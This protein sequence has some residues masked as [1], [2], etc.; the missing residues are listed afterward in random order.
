MTDVN[1]Q[2]FQCVCDG[3]VGSVKAALK[4]GAQVNAKDRHG[5]SPLHFASKKGNVEVME[6]LLEHGA[7]VNVEDGGRRSPLHIASRKANICAMKVLLEHG[8]QVDL[9]D[10]YSRSPLHAASRKRSVE[11]VK[12]LLDHEAEVNLIDMYDVSSLY[13]ASKKGNIKVVKALL[14]RGAQVDLRDWKGRSPLYIASK[15]GNV[16]VVKMLLEH[17]AQVD[18]GDW[19]GRSPLFVASADVAKLLLQF[20]AQ[21]HMVD[22]FSL[23]SPLHV[24]SEKGNV[25]VVSLLLKHGTRVDLRDGG[26]RSPLHIASEKG[27]VEVAKLLLEHEVLDVNLQDNEL[28]TSLMIACQNGHGDL[29]TVL[30]D[31]GA[32]KHSKNSKDQT[33][34]DIAICSSQRDII[35]QITN[36]R[37]SPL[38][39][40]ILFS[41]GVKK[42]TITASAKEIHLRNVGFSLSIPENALPF[43]DPPLEVQIRPCYSGSWEVPENLELVSPAYIMKPS[44]KVLFRKEVSVKIW[45]HANLETEED[46]EDMVFL[47]ASTTPEYRDGRPVYAFQD[48]T[49]VKGSFRPREEQP[50]GE[51]ALKHFCILGIFKRKG[52]GKSILS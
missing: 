13:I 3:D 16:D 37:T 44:R 35:K 39:P 32:D 43:T 34:L 10:I 7:Q 18:L 27:N 25:E 23:T 21:V 45:H 48:I 4:R 14:E 20:G 11:V 19:R 22:K 1:Q 31:A 49:G 41:E 8:A 2:L 33:T 51:I 5:R 40:G 47:S 52:N 30:L 17:G 42:E 12:L 9:L 29:V 26:G 38:F 28:Q 50:A 6:L 36:L 24:A 46:C 15:K